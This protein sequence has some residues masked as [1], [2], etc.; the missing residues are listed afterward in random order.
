MTHQAYNIKGY[1]VKAGS[2][3]LA[4]IGA[5]EDHGLGIFVRKKARQAEREGGNVG[6][7]GKGVSLQQ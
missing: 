3:P 2:D 1:E 5:W 6:E 4:N 7:E